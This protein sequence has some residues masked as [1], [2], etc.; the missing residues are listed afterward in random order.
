MKK[1]LILGALLILVA[2]AAGTSFKP[3]TIEGAQCKASCA[4]EMS[5]CQ[6]S[7]YTCDRAAA[8]CMSSCRELDDIASKK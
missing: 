2:C 3:K 5:S 7:S 4:S 8:T 6:G 1:F